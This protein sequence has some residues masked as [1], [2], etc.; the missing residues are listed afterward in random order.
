M[1]TVRVYVQAEQ[2]PEAARP[3]ALYVDVPPGPPGPPGAPGPALVVESQY[4]EGLP[5]QTTLQTNGLNADALPDR[6]VISRLRENPLVTVKFVATT[7]VN[8]NNAGNSFDGRGILVR[9][10]FLLT[11]QTDP[12]QNGVWRVESLAPTVLVKLDDINTLEHF[13]AF[14]RWGTVGTNTQWLKIGATTF[15][16]IA[17]VGDSFM[18]ADIDDYKLPGDADDLPAVNRA[19]EA[20]DAGGILTFYRRSDYFFSD[21]IVIDKWL[22]LMGVSTLKGDVTILHF[23]GS[24][25]I[26]IVSADNPPGS[27]NPDFPGASGGWANFY[28][29]SLIYDGSFLENNDFH[30]FFVETPVLI[31]NCN[32]RFFPGHSIHQVADVTA[33]PPSGANLCTFRDNR[34]ERAGLSGGYAQGGDANASKWERVDATACGQRK[35]GVVRA[36]YVLRLTNTTGSDITIVANR[37]IWKDTRW[38]FYYLA[39]TGGVVAASGGTLDV[40]IEAYDRSLDA[41]LTA[42]GINVLGGGTQFGYG[43]EYGLPGS[44]PD[45]MPVGTISSLVYA[46]SGPATPRELFPGL[47]ATNPSGPSVVPQNGDADSFFDNA[48]L[49]NTFDTCHS[50]APAVRHYRATKDGGS[51]FTGC[52]CEIGNFAEVVAPNTAI[53]GHWLEPPG[54]PSNGFVRNTSGLRISSA[55]MFSLGLLGASMRL[56]RELTNEFIQFFSTE[57]PVGYKLQLGPAG[58]FSKTMAFM[59]SGAT[60]LVAL[61]LTMV[62]HPRGPGHAVLFR[63]PLIGNPAIRMNAGASL[64]AQST[65]S[66]VYE[67]GDIFFLTGATSGQPWLHRCTAKVLVS[68]TTFDLTWTNALSAPTP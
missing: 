28:G 25:G 57:D 40:T 34:L 23:N 24:H 46:D 36:Q 22:T 63:G 55:L 41:E 13:R 44:D 8:V 7:N 37:A 67:V 16:P 6:V 48:F 1:S 20:M 11:G 21:S 42:E 51:L 17:G 14:T 62:N 64:P 4:G 15:V 49:G 43:T 26:R 59:H 9:D 61:A 5:A 2:I 38:S 53:G 58:P 50:T 18:V 39:K 56:A 35:F 60:N 68:G 65:S 47:T 52:Y 30:G 27:P 66:T 45:L 10:R 3:T 54:I 19:K 33:T 31:E 12:N 29:L 32:V